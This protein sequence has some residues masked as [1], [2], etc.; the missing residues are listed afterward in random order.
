M[1][2]VFVFVL[3]VALAP[4]VEASKGARLVPR[5]AAVQGAPRDGARAGGVARTPGGGWFA[6][7]RARKAA[8][9]ELNGALPP[10][11][12][13]VT[14]AEYR[15]YVAGAPL[16]ARVQ[17]PAVARA[18]EEQL[19]LEVSAMRRAAAT[20][21]APRAQAARVLAQLRVTV[22]YQ[23]RHQLPIDAG[24]IEYA[25]ELTAGALRG[26]PPEPRSDAVLSAL[27]KVA[28]DPDEIVR[29]ASP[30]PG[31]ATIVSKG[32]R[33]DLVRDGH[34]LIY[35]TRRSRRSLWLMHLRV[36][37][38][39]ADLRMLLDRSHIRA[40][41]VSID[42]EHFDPRTLVKGLEPSHGARREIELLREVGYTRVAA[43]VANGAGGAYVTLAR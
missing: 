26:L 17:P 31:E 21:V 9:D 22:A 13:P 23:H 8:R 36:A 39:A 24:A 5:R 37:A 30:A 38:T 28:D 27:E 6:R 33:L 16:P 40:V 42:A 2:S 32:G 15:A 19:D 18:H 10:G 14:R 25:A 12:R 20:H 3:V 29:I 7:A 34:R 43:V 1:V 11:I 41:T 4:G 35:T